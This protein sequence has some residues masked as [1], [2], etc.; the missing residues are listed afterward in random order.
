MMDRKL[1]IQQKLR[2]ARK[3]HICACC[4]LIIQAGDT[5][6]NYTE[7]RAGARPHV[8]RHYCCECWDSAGV[9]AN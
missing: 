5:Y 9:G 3:P 1:E 2:L 6:I 7:R 8:N 4:E